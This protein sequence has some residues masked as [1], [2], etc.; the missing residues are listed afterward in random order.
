M[1]ACHRL[2]DVTMSKRYEFFKHPKNLLD[3]YKFGMK[4]VYIKSSY[5]N[6]GHSLR[7]FS[8]A[9]GVNESPGSTSTE[10]TDANG[11]NVPSIH[12]SVT[13]SED[14]PRGKQQRPTV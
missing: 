13:F 14:F 4:G 2:D 1:V 10:D 8:P 11:R 3:S 9:H 7:T 6:L 5:K 12:E